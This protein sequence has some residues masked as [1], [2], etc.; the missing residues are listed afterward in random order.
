MPDWLDWLATNFVVFRCNQ[1][2]VVMIEPTAGN[3]PI[4]SR[5]HALARL[6]ADAAGDMRDVCDGLSNGH[7]LYRVQTTGLSGLRRDH[8]RYS[9]ATAKTAT[10]IFAIKAYLAIGLADCRI[11]RMAGAVRVCQQHDGNC[12]TGRGPVRF[13]TDSTSGPVHHRHGPMQTD[14]TTPKLRRKRRLRPVETSRSMGLKASSTVLRRGGPAS[15]GPGHID[16]PAT[17]MSTQ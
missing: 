11:G 16:A 13:A 7:W 10:K 15:N 17:T 14:L 9:A 6:R 4:G 12:G 1:F 5:G 3:R 8:R 2:R